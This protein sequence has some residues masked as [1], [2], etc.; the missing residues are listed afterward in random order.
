MNGERIDAVIP[1]RGGSKRL[2]GKNIRLLNGVPLLVHSI[3]YGLDHP[4]VDRVW[5]STDD[6][7]TGEVA[8]AHGAQ[9]IERPASLSA[10]QTP[11][12]AVIQHALRV[13][14]ADGL[15]Q[16]VVT[17]QP[18]SPLRLPEWLTMCIACLENPH[19]DSAMTV[20]PVSTKQGTVLDGEFQPDYLVG[21]RSQ[22]LVP[23]YR[24]N[25]AVY[26]TRASVVA[27]GSV[28]GR[29]IGAVVTDHLYAEIDIDDLADFEN[30]A[31]LAKVA[32]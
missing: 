20:S 6:D 17:L 21:T 25:G 13:M 8:L 27:A 5:V 12:S 19:L 28:F 9:V 32:L 18:T 10:D 29:R 14:G 23:K 24:E 22:D 11:T 1:A 31:A 4:A 16:L 7:E 15:I 2:P 30:A 26:V 3:R